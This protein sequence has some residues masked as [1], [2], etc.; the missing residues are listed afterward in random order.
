MEEAGLSFETM[1]A[2]GDEKTIFGLHPRELAKQ[3]AEFKAIDVARRSP[4]DSL[5]IGADQ[6]L[7]MNGKSYDKAEHEAEARMRLMDFQGKTHE[8]HSAFCIAQVLHSGSIEVV[9]SEVVT[10]PMTM[11]PLDDVKISNYLA[12]GEWQGCVG[13]YRI[14]GKGR[15]LFS[16]IGADIPSIIG[17]PMKELMASLR[18]LN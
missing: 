4:P 17:L 3:R 16:H 15:D 14:E 2:I 6:T 7:G 12:T 11:K 8:L 18:A 1:A 9:S 5:V 10:I 13:C